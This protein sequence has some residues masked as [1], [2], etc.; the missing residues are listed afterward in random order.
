MMLP[1][2]SHIT[3][4]R[5]VFYYRRRL[6]KPMTGELALS[7]RTRTF[8]RAEWLALNLDVVFARVCPSMSDKAKISQVVRAWLTEHLESDMARR[9]AASHSPVYATHLDECEDPLAA[10]LAWVDVELDTAKTELNQRLYEHQRPLIDHLMDL[11]MDVA[12]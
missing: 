1:Q 9:V 8:R 10:D 6:P 5:G 4:K 3:K 11:H 12:G 2:C 7:L